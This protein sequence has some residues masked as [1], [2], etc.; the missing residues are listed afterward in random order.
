MMRLVDAMK[1]ETDALADLEVRTAKLE[2]RL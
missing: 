1:A 2:G